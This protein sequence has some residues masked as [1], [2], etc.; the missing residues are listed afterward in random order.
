LASRPFVAVG[1]ISYGLYLYHLPVFLWLTPL[2]TNLDGL[3]LL[4]L[5]FVVTGAI[6][7]ASYHLVEK[8]FTRRR[9]EGRQPV[10]GLI[11][12]GVLALA[13]IIAV[14]PSHAPPLPS[15]DTIS[16]A[17]RQA[18]EQTPSG[19]P[20]AIVLGDTSVIDLAIRSPGLFEGDAIQG[21]PY[22]MK[23]CDIVPGDLI[24]NGITKRRPVKCLRQAHNLH[25][26][27]T[28]F[29]PSYAVLMMGPT[30]ARDRVVFGDRVS[31]RSQKY[32]VVVRNALDTARAAASV[33]NARFILL[34]VRCHAS[35]PAA[36]IDR[37]NQILAEYAT[38]HP[39]EVDFKSNAAQECA[40][41]SSAAG[42]TWDEIQRIITTR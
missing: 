15:A 19:V 12:V 31:F 38:E 30:D 1:L 40:G 10:G 9:S 8:R 2:S 20:R 26:V 34:P 14:T 6:A 23:N 24:E 36:R 4:C 33:G 22:A 39:A 29:R 16:Y 28:A 5:R 27:V 41:D 7:I 32:R 37:L 21:A 25:E 17:L 11:V 18:A 3:Q 42:W 35:V 13:L